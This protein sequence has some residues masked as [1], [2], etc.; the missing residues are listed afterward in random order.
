MMMFFLSYG[1]HAS[2]SFKC[3]ELL[4]SVE[5]YGRVTSLVGII[6]QLLCLAPT[7]FI[8]VWLAGGN[9]ENV[10]GLLLM[11][12]AFFVV[13]S[14][15]TILFYHPLREV[16]PKKKTSG[17]GQLG[18]LWRDTSVRSLFFP[19]LTRG[20]SMGVIGCLPMLCT[21]VLPMDKT[22]VSGLSTYI[23]IATIIGSV[24]PI[25]FASVKQTKALSVFASAGLLLGSCLLV[26][27]KNVL[28]LSLV[29][30]VIEV[31]YAAVNIAVP[32]LVVHYVP[33]EILGGYTAIRMGATMA[34]SALSSALL[35]AILL[36]YPGKF[37]AFLILAAGGLL[38]LYTGIS[39][40]L[41]KTEKTY[42]K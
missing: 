10:M 26:L 7:T 3:P 15:V 22:E 33:F 11:I 25:I 16:V 28:A 14:S 17:N 4:Y 40:G 12:C 31:F 1:L 6:G 36:A 20:L 42:V 2:F 37:T 29:F 38:Q 24:I 19:N 8:P 35:G 39:Y 13:A 23:V 9:Y 18:K 27:M 32:V 21:H 5:R 34:G 41:Y 30:L